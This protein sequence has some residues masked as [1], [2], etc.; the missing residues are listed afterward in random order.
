[1]PNWLNDPQRAVYDRE[2]GLWCLYF[3]YNSQFSPNPAVSKNGTE[4]FLM[5]S[6]DLVTWTAQHVAIPKYTTENGDPWTGSVVIDEGNTAGFGKGAW[7]ALMTMPAAPHHMQTT[8]LW[9]STDRG[10]RYSFHG[11]VM[12]NPYAARRDLKDK[13]FRDPCVFWH[14]PSHRWVMV[15]AEPEK[16][17]FYASSDLKVWEYT[18]STPPIPDYGVLECPNLFELNV[19]DA[20]GKTTGSRWVLMFGGNGFKG[21]MT[22]GTLYAVGTFDG[23]AF[24]PDR[25]GYSWLD[26]GPDFYAA[27]AWED[28]LSSDRKSHRYAMGWMNN[29][30]YAKDLPKHGY[31]GNLT[32]VRTLTLRNEGGHYCLVSHPVSGQE[33]QY[34]RVHR[35]P[36]QQLKDGASYHLPLQ[37]SENVYRLDFT[38]HRVGEHWPYDIF[39]NLMEHGSHHAQLFLSGAGNSAAVRRSALGYTPREGG[40]LWCAE[41]W[42]RVD[43]GDR[44]HVTVIVERFGIEIFLG[45]GR[46]AFT[47]LAFPD[48]RETGL[49]LSVGTG[50][51]RVTDFVMRTRR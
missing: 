39:L 43:Y 7:I 12:Q 8:A 6:P 15:L 28:P 49:G 3:L 45:D 42:G 17:G 26:S 9:Y 32:T 20:A 48:T 35:G 10:R 46:L 19:R 24:V 41:R 38:L 29:W 31:Y 11:V 30:G 18:G 44:L 14:A 13:A 27:T 34:A 40:D 25:Q 5:T 1:M 23:K 4:W 36:D 47:M 50:E 16:F 22:T 21:G 37:P 33:R 51:I 2:S